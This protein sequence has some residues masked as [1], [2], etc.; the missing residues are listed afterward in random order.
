M[1]RRKRTKG[2]DGVVKGDQPGL[3]SLK[4]NSDEAGRKL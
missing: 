1:E 2:V 3:G 4:Q